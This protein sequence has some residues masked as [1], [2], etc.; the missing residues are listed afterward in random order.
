[1]WKRLIIAAVILCAVAAGV[2]A[3]MNRTPNAVSVRVEAAAR[4]DL[5]SVVTG[6]GQIRPFKEVDI[7]SNVMGR[8]TELVVEEGAEVTEGQFLLRIDPVRYRSAVQQV[9]ASIA[10]A[11]TSLELA[12]QDLEYRRGLLDRREGLYRQDLLSEELYQE[13]VQAVL[14]AERDVQLRSQDIERLRAQLDQTQHDLSQVEFTSPI[15]G[16]ITRLNVEEGETAVTGTM[17]NP[18][19]VL[20]TIADLSVVEAEIE[21]D[22][23]DIVHV[24]LGQPAEVRID[25][26]PDEVFRAEVTEVGRSPINATASATSQAINFKVVVRLLDTVPGA[27]PGLSCTADITTATR[28]QALTVPIQALILREVHLDEAGNIVERDPV[29]EMLAELESEENGGERTDDLQEI[30]G[31]FVVRDGEA[32]FVPIEVGIAGE[33]HFEVLSGLEENDQVVTGPFSVIRTLQT[34]ERVEIERAT[35]RDAA[36]GSE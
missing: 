28:T 5:A 1:M 21:I 36:A 6:S 8:I 14:R 15:N 12:R 20:M 31:A 26:F 19:T 4:R 18:G 24:T 9:E 35:R 10:A 17:N 29:A 2:Y 27:R 13:S 22:E 33:R 25:A 16:V 3:N 34:G 32:V 30:E 7:S 11:E 23:T